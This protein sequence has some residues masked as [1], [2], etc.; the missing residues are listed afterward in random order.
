MSCSYNA[1]GS[2]GCSPTN[3]P[4]I[5][6]NFTSITYKQIISDLKT[7]YNDIIVNRN[8]KS[9]LYNSN[10]NQLTFDEYTRANK[11][12]TEYEIFFNSKIEQLKTPGQ[13]YCS[14]FGYI[15]NPN[16]G[17]CLSCPQNTIYDNN[18]NKCNSNKITTYSAQSSNIISS[19]G[20]CTN[21][22]D[23]ISVAAKGFN[24]AQC[25]KCLI[26]LMNNTKTKCGQ[27]Y[28]T[29]DTFDRTNFTCT[30]PQIYEPSEYSGPYL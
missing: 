24:P 17:I 27:C 5:N 9:K 19:P 2:Y 30:G 6:E 4:T 21:T 8:N 26:G 15:Y 1:N 11:E 20:A 22:P 25:K 3:T 23:T 13:Q 7:K 28:S 29:S 12:Y 14:I 16:T 10:P 18:T